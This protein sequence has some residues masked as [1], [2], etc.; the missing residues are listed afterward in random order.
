[1][2]FFPNE[3]S[4]FLREIQEHFSPAIPRVNQFSKAFLYTAIFFAIHLGAAQEAIQGVIPD[5]NFGAGDVITGFQEPRKIGAVSAEGKFTIPL[6]PNFIEKRKKEIE[7]N[8]PISSADKTSPFMDLDR[9]FRRRGGTIT[10]E[11]AIQPVGTLSNIGVYGV[12]DM[13]GQKLFGVMMA[14]GPEAFAEAVMNMT[15]M[16]F[17][18]GFIIDWYYVDEAATI[19]GVTT[20]ESLAVNQTETFTSSMEYNLE[21]QPGWNM[22]KY[23][24]LS[25][26]QDSTGRTYPMEE[27][28]TSL[29]SF[30]ENFEFVFIP[31]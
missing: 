14:A 6:T 9:V 16:K 21:F 29:T 27:R 4:F 1:M 15:A 12:G 22:V 8:R 20:E 11:N 30:P 24:I 3:S 17:T 10:L 31:K 2:F 25:V 18:P 13:E 19:K 28:Y 26:F 5:W 7:E 23:E